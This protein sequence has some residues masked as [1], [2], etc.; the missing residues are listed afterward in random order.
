MTT[1][2][3]ESIAENIKTAVSAITIA[4]SF[5]QDLVGIRP[6]RKDFEDTAWA[7]GTVLISQREK[8]P[9]DEAVIGSATWWV[10]FA[11]AAIV[12]DSDDAETSIDTRLNQVAADIEKKMM[13]DVTRGGYAIDTRPDGAGPFISDDGSISGVMVEISVLYR[14]KDEDPYTGI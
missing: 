13:E 14:T 5:N 4:N 8:V 6:R 9:S 1:P 3:I 12:I 11:L 10:Q 7:D 2:R